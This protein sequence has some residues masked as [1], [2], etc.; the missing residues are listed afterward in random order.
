MQEMLNLTDEQKAKVSDLRFEHE[1]MVVE[2]KSD[3][4]QNQLIVQ[5]MMS[6]M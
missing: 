3:I 4:E 1:K 5:K 2:V 6:I